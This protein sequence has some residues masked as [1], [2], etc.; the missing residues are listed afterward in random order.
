[1]NKRF[2][3][4]LWLCLLFTGQA[5][6]AQE[7]VIGRIL[8]NA[9]PEGA[10]VMGYDGG[11]SQ[12]SKLDFPASIKVNGVDCPV[13]RIADY[14]FMNCA[15]IVE[16]SL[17]A[18]MKMIGNGAF[19]SC[20]NLAVIYFHGAAEPFIGNNAFVVPATIAPVPPARTLYVL[21]AS[22]GFTASNWGQNVTIVYGGTGTTTYTV[23]YIVDEIVIDSVSVAANSLL[24][25][26]Q[27]PLKFGYF[28]NG[29]VGDDG[30]PW[31]F[32]VRR[33]NANTVLTAMWIPDESAEGFAFDDIHYKVIE[34]S[35][36]VMVMGFAP[37]YNFISDLVIPAAVP[38]D[39]HNMS[40]VSI[41][42][43]AFRNRN[44]GSLTLP[45]TI[46][47][48]GRM[49]FADCDGMKLITYLGSQ[50]P[51]ILPDGF[52]NKNPVARTLNLPNASGGF[53]ASKW[54]ANVTIN[55]GGTGTAE[56]E[57]GG[58]RYEGN[59]YTATALGFVTSPANPVDLVIPDTVIDYLNVHLPV[60]GIAGNAFSGMLI[61][62][63][64]LPASITNI[65]SMAFMEC[66]QLTV[67]TF[68][69]AQEP[70]IG[71]LAF[72]SAVPT[73]PA[74]TLNVPNASSGFTASKWG[75]NVT[76]QY[77]GTGNYYT[78]VAHPAPGMFAT[79]PAG[80]TAG[81]RGSYSIQV[82]AGSKVSNPGIPTLA[83]ETFYGWEV[84]GT[85]TAFDFN[86]PIN[87]NLMLEARWTPFPANYFTV[88]LEPYGGTF[89]TPPAG[90]TEA[91]RGTYTKQVESG[92]LL[93]KPQDPVRQK[94]IFEGWF[95]ANV[96][97]T[98]LEYLNEWNF[99]TDIVTENITLY[100]KWTADDGIYMLNGIVYQ[101]MSNSATGV[102]GGETIAKV[103]S[104]NANQLPASGV[105]VIPAT[106]TKNGVTC[107]VTEIML[108]SLYGA[109]I[110]SLTI[111]ASVTTISGSAF[112]GCTKLASIT[113]LGTAD[114]MPYTIDNACPARVLYVPNATSGFTKEHWGASSI[115]Y[116][117]SA[118]VVEERT[119][120][121][122]TVTWNLIE[123][124]VAYYLYLYSDVTKEG[125]LDT[126][127]FDATGNL[128]VRSS[129][130]PTFNIT[131]L[132]PDVDY[133][134]EVEAVDADDEVILA[135]ALVIPT[136][137]DFESG[138]TNIKDTEIT[139]IPVPVAYYSITGVK[140]NT[141]PEKGIYI[142]LYDNG[143]TKK[144]MR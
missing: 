128:V 80:W 92:R 38:K 45:A 17:P 52:S 36:R 114:P 51:E 140:L 3:T 65:G 46:S 5:L 6:T 85:T 102:G 118:P 29:W 132:S 57:Y 79:P 16:L 144:V 14:A 138:F 108:Q 32:A 112:L 137:E 33:V 20:A 124:A 119:G 28:F 55:Y 87:Q 111:P 125:L 100:A 62:T 61:K 27:D 117:G 71:N 104:H 81:E 84:S 68:L 23:K 2:Y 136:L 93:T 99:K 25:K 130:I 133:Y 101:I 74:R 18:S 13:N 88:I 82:E 59:G 60:A 106:I 115:V 1:M 126:Y 31:D 90:W 98:H 70:T 15:N 11:A 120:T 103:A 97:A 39:G 131:Q 63:L 69:G 135:Q 121:T 123:N 42:D 76:I 122:A 83:G 127:E 30:I 142:I 40:V 19:L 35:D 12:D 95:R 73:Q 66:N 113:Y 41:A 4:V 47:T 24:T 94:Y 49:A 50:E 48:V 64:T 54:G 91:E 139:T 44:L 77:G 8:Y 56:F 96:N 89:A 143:K 7:V 78:V 129:T 105:V 109:P 86:T 53:T 37:S 34:N 107:P 58:I 134:V 72:E 9:T 116:G 10:I 43:Q 110:V 67:I 21:N 75:Q 141:A 26:P 22:S